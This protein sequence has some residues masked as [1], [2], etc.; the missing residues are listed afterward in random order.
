MRYRI[1]ESLRV[2]TREDATPVTAPGEIML[3]GHS[4]DEISYHIKMLY[5]DNLVE[6]V[7][8]SGLGN[9]HWKVKLLTPE[10]HR[11]LD[12]I[13]NDTLWSKIKGLAKVEY[14]EMSEIEETIQSITPATANLSS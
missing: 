2:A 9:F 12:A 13:K 8:V 1:V 7:D 3:E 4:R 5:Q 11:F 14:N 10:G 6:A